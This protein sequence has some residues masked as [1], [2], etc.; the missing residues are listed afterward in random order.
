MNQA[1]AHSSK[2][3]EA[4]GLDLIV[5]SGTV[6]D[7]SGAPPMQA[8]IG[9]SH[10]VIRE[11]GDLSS[12]TA[13]DEIDAH[14]LVVTPGFIDVHSHSDL[15]LVVDGRAQSAL[16]QGVTTE[17]V[18]IAVTGARH[19]AKTQSLRPRY[20]A[21]TRPFPW[22]GNLRPNTWTNSGPRAGDKHR[23]TRAFGQPSSHR[24]GGP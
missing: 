8:D 14:S 4:R 7:G 2:G 16:T 19:Y 10:G 6:V 12:V 24:N 13:V 20:S 1:R 22:T 9:I 15:T 3:S 17:L 23:D 5:R 21:I 11:I 18:G